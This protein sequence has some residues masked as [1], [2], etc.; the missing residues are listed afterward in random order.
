MAT[1]PTSLDPPRDADLLGRF[2]QRRD[3]AAFAELVGRHG[4]IVRAACRRALGETPDA[5][6]AFPSPARDMLLVFYQNR[7]MVAPVQQGKV[8]RPLLR[9]EVNGKPVMVEWALGKYV[10]TWTKQLTP[11]FGNYQ[12]K[13]KTSQ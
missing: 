10:D 2:V 11:H 9:L 6:D 1:A 3:E 8:G 12:P 13:K 5:E 7:L 4:P